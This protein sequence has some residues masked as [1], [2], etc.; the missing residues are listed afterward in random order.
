MA[1]HG[2]TLAPDASKFFTLSP[3]KTVIL[4]PGETEN[5]LVMSLKDEAWKDRIL[6]SH[7]VLHT[8]ISSMK[9]P[10]VCFHGLVETVSYTDQLNRGFRESVALKS[11]A[12]CCE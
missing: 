1:V 10:L 3:F 8:N 2:V 4:A 5:L 7:L 9:V 6:D 11:K 12:Q